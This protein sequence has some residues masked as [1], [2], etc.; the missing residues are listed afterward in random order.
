MNVRQAGKKRRTEDNEQEKGFRIIGTV[1]AVVLTLSG[2]SRNKETL[3]VYNW[4]DYIDESVLG[5]FEKETG[6]KVVY[7]TFATNEDMY[8]K[9]KSGGSQYDLIFPRIT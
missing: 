9:I 2:C 5:E 8:V 6:I 1:D 7:D 3:Y 4:G